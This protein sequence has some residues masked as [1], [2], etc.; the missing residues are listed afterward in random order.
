MEKFEILRKDHP[1][2][3]PN[4]GFG[5]GHPHALYSANGMH[6]DVV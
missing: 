5:K 6:H 3:L 1:L 2:N 4:A